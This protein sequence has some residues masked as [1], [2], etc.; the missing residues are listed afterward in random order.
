MLYSSLYY[1]HWSVIKY[2]NCFVVSKYTHFISI[3]IHFYK[4]MAPFFF[5]YIKLL[6]KKKKKKAAFPEG[7]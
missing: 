5:T 4:H 7:F 3:L 1:V 6:I 2:G